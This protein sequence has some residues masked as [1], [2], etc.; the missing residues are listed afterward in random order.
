M[1]FRELSNAVFRYVLRCAGAEIDGGGVL[2]HPPIRWWKI[3]RPSRARVKH[4]GEGQRRSQFIGSTKALS[5]WR[6]TVIQKQ[7]GTYRR[8]FRKVPKNGEIYISPGQRRVP[9]SASNK[10]YPLPLGYWL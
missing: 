6:P 5:L 1:I 2:K 9:T 8:K 3:Q 7:W 4:S 10:C